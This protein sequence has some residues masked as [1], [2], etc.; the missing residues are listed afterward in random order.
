MMLGNAA[1]LVH[2]P[3]AIHPF[4]CPGALDNTA[5]NWFIASQI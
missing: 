3:E 4:W 5:P 2:V 1:V